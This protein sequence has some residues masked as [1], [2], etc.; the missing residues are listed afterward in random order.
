MTDPRNNKETI[1]KFELFIKDLTEKELSL[2]NKMVIHR[3][4]LMGK[5]QALIAMSTLKV[6]DNVRWDGKDGIVRRG[7]ILRLNHKTASVKFGDEGYWQVSPQL[8]IKEN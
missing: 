8:L 3:F 5:A 6:G 7:V 1:N 2:L 4:K